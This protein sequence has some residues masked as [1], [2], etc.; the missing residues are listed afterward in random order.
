M[1]QNQKINIY[2]P[3]TNK[4]T[5]V[6]PYGRTAK[7][8]YKIYIDE[9]KSDPITILPDNLTY[10]NGRFIKVK[11]V[12]N[13]NN[14]RRITYN[15]V[16]ASISNTS[17]ANSMSFLRKLMKSYRGQTVKL[18]RRYTN[19]DFMIDLDDTELIEKIKAGKASALE[20][21]NI[22][23][24]VEKDTTFI[25]PMENFSA[26][27]K[28][29]SNFF[30]I[31]SDT[32]LF[33]NWN[34]LLKEDPK[35]QSQ[36]LILTLDKVKE[37]NFDQYFLDGITHCL[38]TPIKEWAEDCLE[39]S[40]S[41]SAQK[42]YK[43]IC[44]KIDNYVIKYSKGV[45]E[46]DISIICNDLQISINIDLPSTTRREDKF[47][48]IESQ[49][50]ALKKFKFINTRLNHIELN[51]VC[52]KDNYEEVSKE[53]IK[54]IF[55][56]KTESGE[57]I[58]WKESDTCGITQI[59]ALD[60]IYKLE[61][62]TGYIKAVNDFENEYNIR[63]YA[64]EKNSNKQLTDFL[65]DSV[66]CNQSMTFLPEFNNK[67]SQDY[68]LEAVVDYFNY[69]K[70][71][72]E[73]HHTKKLT[74]DD[75]IYN[76][77]KTIY[78][79]IDKIDDLNHIDMKKAYTQGGRCS[80]YQ[81]YLGK[82]TDFRICD[83]IV[84]LG[85]YKIKNIKFNGC[86]AIEKMKCLHNNQSYPSP[87]LEF[88]RKL[89]IT[90][91]ITMG[92]WGSRFDMEFPS[93]MLEKED[94]LSHYCKWYGCLMRF[95]EYERYTFNC[96]DLDFAKLNAYHA[97]SS[98]IRYNYGE[99]TGI[100]EYRKKYQYH[101]CHLASFIASY[102]RITMLEQILKFK[103]F[104]QI[105]SVV[106]DGIYYVGTVEVG[107]LFSDKEKK[108]LKNNLNCNQY[109]GKVGKEKN[110]SGIGKYR[111]D[112]KLEVHLGAGGAGKTHNNLIDKGLVNTLFIAPSW[113]LCRNKKE[114]YGVDS[115]PF[116]HI[117]DDDPDRWRLLYRNYN[118]F[119]IDEI[120]ML[121][122]E[123]KEKIIKRYPEHKIIFCGDIGYQ[124]DPIEGTEFKIGD[125]PV[126]HHKTNYRCECPKL[127]AIL[128][129]MRKYIEI[130]LFGNNY[131][132]FVKKLGFSIIDEKDMDYSVEDMIICSTHKQK[133]KY[134]NKYKHLEKYTV[135]ENTRDYSNG[136]IIIGPKPDKVRCELRH[137]Y[138]VH[139][140]QGE[141]AK[142]KLFIN[143]QGINNMK[144][145]Y[146]SVS[147][148][149]R[150]DQIVFVKSQ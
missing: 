29:I 113:K 120:S 63:S 25:V 10:L 100:I 95:S 104:N 138:T 61:T 106:V 93:A 9:L 122:N 148:C 136:E 46:K 55:K 88:Y 41:K 85:I 94:D 139:S 79:W 4:D 50:K 27:W 132:N 81:G 75:E 124:L 44:K 143:I 62:N 107:P 32:D 131:E 68:A 108:S 91:D 130:G 65:Y 87:E 5:K 97:K 84:G 19:F 3:I 149:K 64:I 11:P 26:W 15:E 99:E 42:R 121:S 125:I 141:T 66:N 12:V 117:L 83:K 18:V 126:V 147:R 48:E 135:L 14:V 74:I 31:N 45:P 140:V 105:Y 57:F 33:G 38:F 101:Y 123:D 119:I 92:C 40:K 16:K 59:N 144:L 53:D 30:W 70:E 73:K 24:Q 128:N 67:Y 13:T 77:K 69:E 35:L 82:I 37:Q 56:Q 51:K 71:L 96:K 90:F 116:F 142:N 39:N 146:T 103:D 52:S 150:F 86:S 118:T 17:S 54:A 112:N 102:S 137:A 109:V 145:L 111:E 129:L 34:E 23:E 7:N 115:V 110:Y 89:G 8:I 22:I 114:E 58:L 76:D 36:L 78:D 133:D 60:K 43:T 21:I 20:K 6:D 127:Q 28:T 2:N 1:S 98:S 47:I 49:K 80:M 134:T 72:Y